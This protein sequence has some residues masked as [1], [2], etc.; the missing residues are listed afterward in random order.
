MRVLVALLA[1]LLVLSTSASAAVGDRMPSL[2]KY[3]K[4][5]SEDYSCV[6]GGMIVLVF[7][8]TPGVAHQGEHED[9]MAV[10]L[11][12]ERAKRPFL[13]AILYMQDDAVMSSVGFVDR[14]RDGVVDEEYPSV[15]AF[16]EKYPGGACELARAI[17]SP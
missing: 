17:A 12:S 14:N 8:T 16:V 13:V 7:L 6:D 2:F 15:D 3:Q 9:L 4:E 10:Y 1:F 5:G 11:T